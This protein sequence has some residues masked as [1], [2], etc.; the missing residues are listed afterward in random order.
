MPVALGP[1]LAG[2]YE[3]KSGPAPGTVLVADPPATLIDGQ[4]VKEKA[5]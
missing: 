4:P 2:G 5:K 3:V 1:E